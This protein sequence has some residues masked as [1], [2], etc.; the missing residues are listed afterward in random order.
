MKY[1]IKRLEC[2]RPQTNSKKNNRKK[3]K[4]GNHQHR[5]ETPFH[6]DVLCHPTGKYIEGKGGVPKQI[7]VEHQKRRQWTGN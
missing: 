1:R 3:N 2:E 6:V 7:P 4:S 5:N